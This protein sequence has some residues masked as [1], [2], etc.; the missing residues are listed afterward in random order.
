MD[1]GVFLHHYWTIRGYSDD[2]RA[3]GLFRDGTDFDL[4]W[5]IVRNGKA[6]FILE[7]SSRIFHVR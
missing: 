5:L 4:E 3:A 2:R 1:H 6:A 7:I